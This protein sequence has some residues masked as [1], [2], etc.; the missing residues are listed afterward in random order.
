[1]TAQEMIRTV[2]DRHGTEG[3]FSGVVLVTRGDQTFVHEAYSLAHRGFRVSNTVDTRF[4]IASVT[5]IF[6]AAAIMQVVDRGEIALDT[7]VIPFIGIEGTAI[8]DKVTVFHCLTH[9]SG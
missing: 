3:G 7:P 8:S 2:I 1:M 6:T 9:T 4:D 5:K